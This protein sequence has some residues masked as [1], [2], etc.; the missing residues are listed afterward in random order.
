MSL[1]IISR[2]STHP[3]IAGIKDSE[4]DAARQEAL[5][6]MFAMRDDFAV[7]CGSVSQLSVAMRHGADGYVPGVGNL[8]P[9]LVRE[10]M[11]AM[12]ADDE[13]N[14]ASM[15]ERLNTVNAIYQ[16]GRSVSEMFAAL[17]ALLEVAGLC[18]R[19][20]LPPLLPLTNA[21]VDSLRDDMRKN[22]IEL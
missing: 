19:H 5:A 9:R 11:D 13:A 22:V 16:K 8:L 3:W 14:G 12:L 4:A 21:E 1:D 17:K 10:A 6:S 20:V 18:E 2:L 15:Q 7:F